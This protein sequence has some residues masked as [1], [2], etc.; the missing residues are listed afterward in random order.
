MFKR[1]M[2]CLAATCVASACSQ[3]P[4][5]EPSQPGAGEARRGV[6]VIAQEVILEREAER[7]EVLGTAR[8]RANATI[9]PETAGQVEAVAFSA[10]E[11]VEGGAPLVRL[12]ADQER[13]EVRLSEVAV[14]EAE[15]LL[16]RYRRIENTGAVSDSQIDEAETALDAA[17][18]ELEQARIALARRTVYAPFSGYLGLTDIDAGARITPSTA[19]TELD[20]RSVLYVDFD[21]SEQVFSRIS[22]GDRVQATPFAGPEQTYSARI[23][24]V[25]SRI[26]PTSRTF[27]VRAEIDNQADALR[28]GM[29][30]RVGFELLS[31]T[32]PVV[33]EAA[34]SWGS[35]G[36]YVW[37]V[38]DGRAEREA[39]TLV[40]RRQGRVLVSGDL[41]AGELV[42]AEG[43]QRMREGAA[44]DLLEIRRRSDT[45]T[46]ATAG[47][48]S[49]SDSGLAQ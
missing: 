35:D 17:R 31:N 6:G 11:W 13:L 25:D 20:D 1:L 46:R 18:I 10:G 36:A 28:P 16:A 43:V 24:N 5:S 38:R 41:S 26:D 22:V 47:A 40:Q 29:S 37:L 49:V 33:P 7:I 2:V 4:S 45:D 14:R 3:D 8:A 15:Q 12:E 42:V 32:R 21:P 27:T 48:T 19:I 34:I 23:I 39:V 30:F 9:Y 44:V